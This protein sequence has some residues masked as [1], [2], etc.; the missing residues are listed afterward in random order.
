MTECTLRSWLQTALLWCP[1]DKCGTYREVQTLSNFVS[2]LARLWHR[3]DPGGVAV[4]R[5]E[6]AVPGE[7]GGPAGVAEGLRCQQRAVAVW[8]A[9]GTRSLAHGKFYEI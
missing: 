5:V 2:D 3:E 4:A 7:D 8:T 6:V 1:G 9:D